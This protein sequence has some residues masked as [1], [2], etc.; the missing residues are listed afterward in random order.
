MYTIF[1]NLTTISSLVLLTVS[2]GIFAQ[3]SSPSGNGPIPA[4]Q[5]AASR[6]DPD[7]QPPR[8]SWGHP[9][10][11]GVWT[12]DEMRLVPYERP[13]EFGTREYLT[14]EEFANRVE[15]GQVL[16]DNATPSEIGT[17]S[18]T[19]LV[20]EP[21][22]GRFPALTEAGRARIHTS[23]RGSYGAG[24][25]DTVEDFTTYDRCITRG[26]VGSIMPVLY[27]N[28]IK[29]F[30]TPSEVIINY[31]MV[32]ETR[33]IPVD[34]RPYLD[35]EIRQWLGSS[36]GYWE[37]DTLVVETR[38]LTDKTGVTGRQGR[39]TRHS[40]EMVITER[41]TRIDEDMIDYYLHMDDPVT[42]EEPFTI[43]LTITT[44]PDYVMY[45]Y[46]CHEG[47]HSIANMLAGD[48]EYERRAK[49]A[50]AQ[51]LP[52]PPQHEASTQFFGGL[53]APDEDDKIYNINLG[54]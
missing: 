7:W 49:E 44:Q 34:D 40:E 3:G 16:F 22:N 12:S 47:N 9:D 43:R 31:E 37:G 17:F 36:R 26:I 15:N 18:Y 54:E 33:V 42:Y 32:H 14:P 29:I 20:V 21:E 27:G 41:F 2:T 19:S 23:D 1:K 38:N 11:Q 48:R 46:S 50:A 28:G 13:E 25:F 24:P 8:T 51:G 6:T 35:E 4:E 45:E 39:G 10:L 53:E 52:I 30:Q 5:T